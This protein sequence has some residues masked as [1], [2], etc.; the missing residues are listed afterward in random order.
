M[1]LA[2]VELA[3]SNLFSGARGAQTKGRNVLMEFAPFTLTTDEKRSQW[4]SLVAAYD[5]SLWLAAHK[6]GDL[7]KHTD[8]LHERTG[9]FIGS[10]SLLV[11]DASVDAISNGEERITRATL[12]DIELDAAAE[13]PRTRP[14]ARPRRKRRGAA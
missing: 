7:L 14:L 11:R 9:G 8:Y 2:G 12:D 3:G 1:V 13:S 5:E 10:L 6:P 4:N